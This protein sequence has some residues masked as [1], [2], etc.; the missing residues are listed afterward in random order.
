M[1]APIGG[2]LVTALGR[3]GGDG[4]ARIGIHTRGGDLGEDM[5]T[6]GEEDEESQKEGEEEFFH[7]W[8]R[9]VDLGMYLKMGEAGCRRVAVGCWRDTVGYYSM[10]GGICQGVGDIAR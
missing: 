8:L 7:G 1:D 3:V 9:S 2:S 10:D 5:G 6:G 4:D